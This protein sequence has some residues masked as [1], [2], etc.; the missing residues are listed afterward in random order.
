MIKTKKIISALAVSVSALAFSQTSV[1]VNHYPQMYDNQAKTIALNTEAD[2]SLLST[3]EQIDININ[4][5]V[6][7]PVLRNATW[8]FVIYDPKTNKIINSYNENLPL[9]PASTTKLLTTDTAMSI[10]GPKFRWNTQ[11]DYSGSIDNE[12]TLSGNL[13]IIGS[14][15]PSLGTNKAGAS[16]YSSIVS[17]FVSAVSQLGIKKVAGDIIVENAVFANSKKDLPKNIVWKE[18]GAY[19]LPVGS[20]QNINPQNEQLTVKQAN[21]FSKESRYFYVSPY[22]NKMVFANKFDGA[23][24]LNTKLPN[25]PNYLA[26][27]FRTS[28][29][30][31]GISVI[32]KVVSRT[33]ET[34]LEDRTKI[35][36]YQSPTLSEIVTYTNKH[37]DNG[38][39]ETLLRT[40]GFQKDGDQTLESG[41]KVVNEHLV[42]VGFD[43]S[44]LN[45]VDG[46]G[47]S[48]SHR[49][50]P[51]SQAKFLANL[52]K[53]PYYKEYFDSLPI[54]GQDGT[55]KKMFFGDGYG[56]IF[57]KT[58][59][60]N[61]VKCLA[62]YIKTRNGK[63]LT[64]SLLVN[65][66]AGSVDSVK[67]RMEQ[68]L[69]PAVNL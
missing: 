11:L 64:F 3:K 5:L 31:N 40:V 57:A 18:Q 39:A 16:S 15:D 25:T 49:V 56:Q 1:Y 12:G 44:S 54:G 32:G 8:G 59:T 37:S 69:N 45:Y 50:T 68:L 53:A 29:L 41:K 6:S 34:S 33:V 65:D 23:A 60:L 19:Y 61:K 7:D 17:D 9:V 13:Y 48:R 63:T 28:L 20:T 62:G 51:I 38:L 42:S 47:L 30:K 21:P 46:S 26:N 58:G 55:L 52:M 27:T 66:Y 14:G 2:R 10:L 36:L 43:V 24:Y 4:T 67:N 22:I 35:A